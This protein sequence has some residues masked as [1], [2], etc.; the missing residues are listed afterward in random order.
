M[1]AQ[2]KPQTKDAFDLMSERIHEASDVL[3]AMCALNEGEHP[4]HQLADMTGQSHSA[5]SQHLAKL[6]AAG[7]VE[8]RRDAQTIYY[9]C[10]GGI[11]RALVDT[12]CAYYR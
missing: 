8:S 12:L 5:V 6:R 2:H 7:L 4:V 3:K 11:G 9:R 1:K 10:A